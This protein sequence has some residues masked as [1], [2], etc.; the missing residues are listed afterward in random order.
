MP[1]G[2]LQ[3]QRV[4]RFASRPDLDDAEC[5]VEEREE[6]EPHIA[7]GSVVYAGVDYADILAEAERE[8]D[9]IIW[10][11]GNNDFSFIRPDLH[12]VLTDALRPDD[13]DAYHPGEAVLRMADVIVIAKTN[14]ASHAQVAEAEATARA[15]NPAATIVRG[16]SPVTLDDPEAVRGKRVLVID[17]GPTLTH[18]GMAYGAGYVAAIAAGAQVVDPLPYA[19][20]AIRAAVARYPQT[21][22]VL[23]ALGYGADQLVALERSITAV[24]V[25][26]VVSG[27]PIDL[28]ALVRVPQRIIRARYEFADAGQPTLGS[29]VDEALDRLGLTAASAN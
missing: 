27:T 8:A 6:Y 2:D 14:A 15:L 5:T 24:P 9:I 10:D 22:R 20:E 7:S 25:D 13:A 16:A 21:P 29:V 18:G 3:R 1:Y 23:P 19:D 17:D 4:Q 28:A 12:V 11:G 26:L